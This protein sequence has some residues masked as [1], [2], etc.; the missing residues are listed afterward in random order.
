[1]NSVLI[2]MKKVDTHFFESRSLLSLYNKVIIFILN[3]DCLQRTMIQIEFLSAGV[4][5]ILTTTRNSLLRSHLVFLKA[6]VCGISLFSA[7]ISFITILFIRKPDYFQPS[8]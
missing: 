4:I 8:R 6:L 5:M 7:V 3:V 2:L 1:M